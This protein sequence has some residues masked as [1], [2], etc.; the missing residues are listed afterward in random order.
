MTVRTVTLNP[1]IDRYTNGA[2]SQEE[3]GGKGIN[4]AKHLYKLGMSSVVSYGFEG[5]ENGRRLKDMMRKRGLR[6]SFV[7][8]GGE[9]RVTNVLSPGGKSCTRSPSVSRKEYEELRQML[10]YESAPGD[11]LVL[12]GS[13]PPGVAE[14]AYYEMINDTKGRDIEV[15]LDASQ[16]RPLRNGIRARPNG[17][18]PNRE[19]FKMLSGFYWANNVPSM[20]NYCKQALVDMDGI[21]TVLL[22]LDESGGV[23][24]DRSGALHSP[25]PREV[26][27]VCTT[28]PGD[29]FL[30]GYLYAKSRGYDTPE[31]LM[32]AVGCGT[33]HVCKE[34]N[35]ELDLGLADRFF[36]QSEPRRLF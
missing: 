35:T 36:S 13:L 6:H 14:S 15:F 17:I 26:E 10:Y 23:L 18:K 32:M 11:T 19:E 2:S 24:V 7:H 34:G 31:C 21:G 5:G 12:A 25:A 27:V 16:E 20:A 9:T 33:A 29:A 1:A 22:S 4:V 30:A 8:I 3:P 28:G